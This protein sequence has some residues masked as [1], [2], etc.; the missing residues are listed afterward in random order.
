MLVV[1]AP[2]SVQIMKSGSYERVVQISTMSYKGKSF[3]K[4]EKCEIS[5]PSL[6]PRSYWPNHPKSSC[7]R[8]RG[9]NGSSECRSN[10]RQFVRLDHLCCATLRQ[11]RWD[12]QDRQP[13]RGQWDLL[14]SPPTTDFETLVLFLEI[15]KS[16]TYL[17]SDAH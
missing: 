10:C 14:S 12:I 6:D 7:W 3:K 11:G 17:P 15:S 13:P 16:S 4:N 5:V 2:D 8:I 9:K 1:G